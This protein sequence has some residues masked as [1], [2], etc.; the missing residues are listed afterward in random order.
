MLPVVYTN[1]VLAWI[2]AIT[3]VL[4]FLSE[5]VVM[6]ARRPGREARTEDRRSALL[7]NSC[8]WG[9][10]LIANI[11][12][13]VFRQFAI[14]WHRTLQFIAGILLMLMGIAFRW[15]SIRVLGKYFTS[16]VAIQQDHHVVEEGPYRWIRHPSYTGALITFLGY[17]LSLGN[18]FSLLIVCVFVAVG[19]SYRITVEERALV[20]GLGDSYRAY[21]KRTKRIIPFV[22]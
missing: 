7:L 13:S 2:F 8:I 12:A 3:V 5:M 16:M 19:Y 14:P 22:I 4:W 10:I 6:W 18:W 17:G 11:A 15:Y 1:P 9:G 20:E 21:M